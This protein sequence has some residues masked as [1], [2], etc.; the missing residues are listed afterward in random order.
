M[1][2]R[3]S[4]SL[5]MSATNSR[6]V[7]ASISF[8]M[9]ESVSSLMEASGV[10]SSWEA[11]ETNCR[12]ACSEAWRRS[13]SLLNSPARRPYSSEPCISILWLYS[14]SR[15]SSMEVSIRRIFREVIT[16]K[17][18]ENSTIPAASPREIRKMFRSS[19]W[20][21]APRSASRSEIYTQPMGLP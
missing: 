8:C 15:A 20:M 18:S 1:R 5:P 9:M 12:W 11:S 7:S 13:V 16:A 19:A 14:P 17:I 2:V 10:F 4:A 3:R 6:M 21:M